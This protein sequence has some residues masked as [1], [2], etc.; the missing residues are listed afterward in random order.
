MDPL[1]IATVWAVVIVAGLII[2][3]WMTLFS[4]AAMAKK[5]EAW[6]KTYRATVARSQGGRSRDA[7]E[8]DVAP[9][10]G[11]MLQG[12]G[13]D[14]AVLLEDEMPQELKTLLPLAKGFVQSGGLKK[15]LDQGQQ[16][17][18]QT[19]RASI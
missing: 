16:Q 11:E 18:G 4:E 14:P 19:D 17:P 2:N 15:L 5:M 7:D 10:V 6:K 13:I 3:R 12:F 9:W 8:P 1:V